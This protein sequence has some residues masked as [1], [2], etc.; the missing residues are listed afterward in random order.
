[1]DFSLP[2]SASDVRGL[3]RDIATKISTDDRVAELE[4]ASAPIDADL[5]RE[6]GTAGLLGLELSAESVG[7]AGGDLSAIENCG[8]AEELGRVLARVPFGP[9]AVVALPV[10]ASTAAPELADRV[11]TSAAAG[12]TVL[13][14]AFEEELGPDLLSPTTTITGG[15][16]PS[17]RGTK[18]NVPYGA[19][20]DAFVVSASGPD[21]A[22]AVVVFADDPGVRVT[23]TISTGLVPTAA[24]DFDD[25]VLPAGR[26]LSGGA[27]TVG[28]VADRITLAICAEQTGI[29]G[30]ALELTAQY[31]REREQFGRAIGSFQAVAQRL[32]DGYIDAQGLALTTTQAAWL[33]ATAAE[34]DSGI[35]DAEVHTAIATAKFWAADAGHRVAHTTVHV[36]GGV[37]LD[38]THP[39]H[40]YFL[41]AKQN[42]FTFG[43]ATAALRAIGVTLADTPA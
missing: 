7:D 18:L 15:D 10:I 39:V 38:T 14:V 33:L 19:A 27:T 28:V 22:V 35:T 34:A 20:A 32:A 25:V 2:E 36:H 6:L 42:E 16:A 31:A 11:L 8:V 43:P 29:V 1:M 21:G 37:G 17:L 12:Q 30:R 5:W 24:V 9:H 40:R 3:T 13:T 41:R 26:I 4:S 23:P